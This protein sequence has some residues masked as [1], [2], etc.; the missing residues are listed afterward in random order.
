MTFVHPLFIINLVDKFIDWFADRPVIQQILITAGICAFLLFLIG[1]SYVLTN[2]TSGNKTGNT[3]SNSSNNNSSSQNPIGSSQNNN[4]GTY[5]G[6]GYQINYPSDVSI[7]SGVISGGAG[8][9][10]LIIEGKTP[11]LSK[12]TISIQVTNISATPLENILKIFRG[13][14]YKESEILLSNISAKKFTG[15]IG[16]GSF[17]LQET[18]IAFENRGKLYKID[19][20]YEN[21]QKNPKI[22]QEFLKILETFKLI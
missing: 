22:E 1:A 9:T 19:L 17:V 12:F 15:Q 11:D 5:K 2:P 13:F 8:G 10:A 21:A 4:W 16:G 14:G 6:D 7:Q 18:V 20:F 3:I